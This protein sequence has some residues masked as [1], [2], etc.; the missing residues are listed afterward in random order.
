MFSEEHTHCRRNPF[1]LPPSGAPQNY[2]PCRFHNSSAIQPIRIEI[3]MQCKAVTP[4]RRGGAPPLLHE[5]TSLDFRATRVL[6]DD[7]DRRVVAAAEAW[8]QTKT[9]AASLHKRLSLA[10]K[11]TQQAR[12]AV[13]H[14]IPPPRGHLDEANHAR[15]NTTHNTTQH[16]TPHGTTQHRTARHNTSRQR[17]NTRQTI[18]NFQDETKHRTTS[19]LNPQQNRR[20]TSQCRR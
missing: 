4:L 12:E 2:R 17:Q 3:S 14:V 20:D 9:L 5:T 7:E 13:R 11:K 1:A 15:H 16:D 19:H 10:A 6:Q 8:K 18:L